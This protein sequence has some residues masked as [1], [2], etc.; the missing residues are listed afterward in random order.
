MKC[1]S[2][3]IPDTTCC[4]NCQW[5]RSRRGCNSANH[6]DVK[7]IPR[8]AITTMFLESSICRFPPPTAP[9]RIS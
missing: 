3:I 7:C 2:L 9:I 1:K 5:Q 6:D 8:G 4:H